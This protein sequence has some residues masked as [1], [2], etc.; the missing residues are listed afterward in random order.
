MTNKVKGPD[1]ATRRGRPAWV[2]TAWGKKILFQTTLELMDPGIRRWVDAMVFNGKQ[3]SPQRFY[4]A[5]AVHHHLKTGE[6]FLPNRKEY[7]TDGTHPKE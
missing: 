3:V 7:G 2:Q 1:A 6:V 5:Y 4:N